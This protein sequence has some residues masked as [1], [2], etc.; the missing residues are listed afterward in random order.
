MRR[1]AAGIVA[2]AALSAGCGSG[3]PASWA[4]ALRTPG[5]LGVCSYAHFAPV[6]YGDGRGYEPDLLRA[7]AERWN[8]EV[9]FRPVEEFG[10]IWLAP[11]NP[12][13]GCDLAVGGITPTEQR[14]REGA[15]FGPT[16]ARFAQSLLVRTADYESGRITGY[17][18]FAGTAMVIGVVPGTTGES[19]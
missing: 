5:T 2:L 15:V 14:V 9:S 13:L 19:P 3:S 8:V 10:G 12:A 7:V 4:P 18:S 16:T 6:S 11:S 1:G 17:R